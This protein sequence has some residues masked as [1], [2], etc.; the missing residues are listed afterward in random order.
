MGAMR[1]MP[2]RKNVEGAEVA[3]GGPRLYLLK[4]WRFTGR[5]DDNFQPTQDS[6]EV[7][8]VA[9]P[10][11]PLVDLAN[12]GGALLGKTPSEISGVTVSECWDNVAVI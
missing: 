11:T 3:K 12:A 1:T 2:R 6:K 10:P 8:V 7:W 9:T 4:V 5:V